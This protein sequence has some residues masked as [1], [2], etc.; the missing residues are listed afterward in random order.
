M[1][2]VD[3]IG[4]QARSREGRGLSVRGGDSDK[5]ITIQKN[6]FQN[7][8]NLQLHGSGLSVDN[9]QEDLCDGVKLCVLVASLQQKPSIG[10]VIRK[11]NNQHQYL[12]NVTLALNAIA[13]DNIRLV[14]IGKQAVT[15]PYTR[16]TFTTLGFASLKQMTL[17]EH[18]SRPLTPQPSI[19]FD[20]INM[21]ISPIFH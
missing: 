15:H 20:P 18:D 2:E 16:P 11:P 13:A 12:E 3:I 21:S 19:T 10:R 1:S 5:W 14:N 17:S 7:W 8:I 9:L 6:T 4:N